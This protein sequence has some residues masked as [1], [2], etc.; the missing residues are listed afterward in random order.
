MLCAKEL[1]GEIEPQL[2]TL[3]VS[4][5]CCMG[6]LFVVP[7][8]DYY[9]DPVNIA[10]KL[11]EDVARPG[12]MLVLFGSKDKEMKQMKAFKKNATFAPKSTSISNVDIEYY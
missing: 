8:N 10:A 3:D 12:E 9:G 6:S 5:G 7:P 4:S 2:A 11:S 1:I